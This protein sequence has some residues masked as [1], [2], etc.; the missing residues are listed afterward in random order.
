MIMILNDTYMN[1][2]G[3]YTYTYTYTRI[4]IAYTLNIFDADVLPT[5]A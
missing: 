1:A 3:I 4:Y 5:G 2:H